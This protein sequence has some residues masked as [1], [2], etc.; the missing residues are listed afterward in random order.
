MQVHHTDA[1]RL[2]YSLDDV[3][4]FG[5]QQEHLLRAI[6]GRTENGGGHLDF[7]KGDHIK[8]AGNHL[9]GFSLGSKKGGYGPRNLF[10]SYKTEEETRVA[11]FP[12]YP[13]V[14]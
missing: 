4:Y 13:E 3:Y 14:S 11:N 2:V 9:N 8:I 12:T 10:P 7:A 5:G 6:H 1:S